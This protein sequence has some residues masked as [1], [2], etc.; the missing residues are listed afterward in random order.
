MKEVKNKQRPF[1]C[2]EDISRLLWTLLKSE[3]SS[4][5]YV[6]EDLGIKQTKIL[7]KPN[8]ETVSSERE[9]EQ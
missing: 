7:K 3:L 1:T 5:C 2:T 4:R 6:S 9:L 8:F